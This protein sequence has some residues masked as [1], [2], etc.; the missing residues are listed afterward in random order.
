[1]S[2]QNMLYSILLLIICLSACQKNHLNNLDRE[3]LNLF[4]QATKEYKYGNMDE[5]HSKFLE[6][7]YLADKVKPTKENQR[8]HL[9]ALN[10]LG[11]IMLK[12]GAKK[13][14]YK[15]FE[16]ALAL[17][18]RYKNEPYQV[19]ATL[20][21]ARLE[22]APKEV[23]R[24]LEITNLKFGSNRENK[25]SLDQIK[26]AL[27]LLY[28]KNERI[29]DAISIFKELLEENY[30]DKEKS[31]FY[32]GLGVTY[33]D[34]GDFKSAVQY[35]NI[36]LELTEDINKIDKL[37]LF[38]EKA[39][40]YFIT[41]NIGKFDSLI[42]VIKPSISNIGDINLKKRVCE[43]E[44]EVY[45]ETNNT[46]GKLETLSELLS[47]N[48]KIY[49]KSNASLSGIALNL[50][51]LELKKEAEAHKKMNN[52]LKVS[53]ALAF[54]LFL[55]GML[56]LFLFYKNS[57]YKNQIALDSINYYIDVREADIV[58]LADYLHD[59][60]N[61]DL[62]AINMHINTIKNIVPEDKFEQ[63]QSMLRNAIEKIR[64]ISH[65]INPPVLVDKGL[66]AAIK[67]KAFNWSCA[68]LG[69]AVESNI[70]KIPF[71]Q[72][73]LEFTLYSCI[74]ECMNNIIRHS[75]ASEALITFN[76]KENI[77]I[78]EVKDNGI[79]FAV[80]EFKSRMGQRI[81][82]FRG[83]FNIQS[84]KNEGTLII[85]KVPVAEKVEV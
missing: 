72:Y 26:Y 35:F 10:Y 51:N 53:L 47:L 2:L 44:L 78:I 52:Q 12:A 1:M 29:E 65:D 9:I 57:I 69:F 43:L 5:S 30:S 11:D 85:I 71:T 7:L 18:E 67:E 64:N 33:R 56:S 15:E 84:K 61:G 6:L 23:E 59:V 66:I 81:K 77:L 74:T 28:A 32:K 8:I 54:L 31:Y 68:S 21:K 40:L 20:N 34:N 75:K 16:K 27:G 49:K 17:A 79:G 37:N 62:A 82:Y 4:E 36:A 41:K 25:Y 13:L 39:S 63:I 83:V 24:V 76:F 60:V 3:Y 45:K 22:E 58:K 48:E 50:K 46:S 38:V 42:S 14:A 73:N 19:H 70:D 80:E 55:S